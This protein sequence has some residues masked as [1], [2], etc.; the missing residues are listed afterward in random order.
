MSASSIKY[1]LLLLTI[2]A[3]ASHG[4]YSAVLRAASPSPLY[5]SQDCLFNLTVLPASPFIVL[6]S[7]S[8]APDQGGIT[9]TVH[10]AGFPAKLL[11]LRDN[12]AVSFGT[13]AAVL[14]QTPAT[15]GAGGSILF[16]RAP[17]G[18]GLSLISVSYLL[19]GNG[20]HPAT[21]LN[22]SQTFLYMSSTSRVKCESHCSCDL[23]VNTPQN[24]TF[25]VSADGADGAALQEPHSLV[26]GCNVLLDGRPA[27][28]GSDCFVAG[29]RAGPVSCDAAAA[30]VNIKCLTVAVQIMLVPSALQLAV[31]PLIQ[32]FVT[33]KNAAS[34]A[35]RLQVTVPVSFRRS[36]RLL[37]AIFSS[38][39]G[40]VVLTFDQATNAP[41]LNCFALFNVQDRLLGDEPVCQW[42]SPETMTIVL[43]S[44]ATILPGD[45]LM[46]QPDLSDSAS[47][48]VPAENLSVTVSSPLIPLLPSVTVSGPDSVSQCDAAQLSASVSAASGATFTWNCA[49]DPRLDS[50]LRNQTTGPVV[51]ILGAQL[52][53]G[54]S[55]FISVQARS[56]FGTV[57]NLA[58]RTLTRAN[59]AQ[60]LIAIKMQPPPCFRSSTIYFEAAAVATSCT[61]SS[62]NAGSSIT[63]FW[64]LS[65][66][67]TNGTQRPPAVQG[68]GPQ[69]SVPAGVLEAG[70]QFVVT[71]TG[72]QSGLSPAKT[73]QSFSI[74]SQ[75]VVA[76]IAGGGTR[77]LYMRGSS[78][79]DASPSYDPDTCVYAVN[80]AAGVPGCVSPA[81]AGALVFRWTCIVAGVPCSLA[82]NGS[83]ASFSAAAITVLDLTLLSLPSPAPSEVV[84]TVYVSRPG[85]KVGGDAACA[86][87]TV[88]ISQTPTIDVQ[89]VPLYETAE[90][91]AYSAAVPTE[92]KDSA[93]YSWSLIGMTGSAEP[94][95]SMSDESTFLAGYT[96]ASFVL[97]LV[98]ATAAALSA[99]GA[100]YAVSL[101]V[102]AGTGAGK[103][104][105]ALL[106]PQQPSGGKCVCHP[107]AGTPLVT[108]FAVLCAD[109]AA[110]NLPMAYSYAAALQGAINLKPV[111]PLVSWSAP[112]PAPNY[113]IFLLA[114]NYSVAARIFDT[115]GAVAT[116][117]AA[118]PVVVGASGGAGSADVDLHAL[119]ALSDILVGRGSTGTALT[120]FDS[121]AASLNT[122]SPSQQG[123]GGSR[124]LAGSSAAY[125][126][127]VRRMLLQRLSS[128]G[129]ATTM[130][131]P[132]II[133]ATRRAV[134]VPAEV[135][136]P[137]AIAAV[138]QLVVALGAMDLRR[139]RTATTFP[140]A[141][142]LVGSTLAA[143]AP[144]L[145]EEELAVL[146]A[147]AAAALLAAAQLYAAGM[148]A[149]E[150]AK[151]IHAGG[152]LVLEMASYGPAATGLSVA[153]RW[154]PAGAGSASTQR[155]SDQQTV[156][157]SPVAV[158]VLRIDTSVGSPTA[159]RLGVDIAS[160][161]VLAIRV[162]TAATSYAPTVAAAEAG[163]AAESWACPW[164]TGDS[165]SGEELTEI[166]QCTRFEIAMRWT[167]GG[168][169]AEEAQYGCQRWDG[170]TWAAGGC[171]EAMSINGS[172]VNCS[173]SSDGVFTVAALFVPTMADMPAPICG[174]LAPRTAERGAMVACGTLCIFFAA[175]AAGLLLELAALTSRRISLADEE[176][177]RTLGLS[178]QNVGVA[179]DFDKASFSDLFGS[180]SAAAAMILTSASTASLPAPAELSTPTAADQE[181]DCNPTE[182]CLGPMLSPPSP[183]SQGSIAA[184]S[185]ALGLRRRSDSLASASLLHALDTA[186]AGGG[187]VVISAELGY[188]VEQPLRATPA[189]TRQLR[190]RPPRTS[191]GEIPAAFRPPRPGRSDR[192]QDA[193][194]NPGQD[195]DLGAS[196]NVL[197]DAQCRRIVL[198]DIEVI[199]LD[200]IE[201]LI[202]ATRGDSHTLSN[203]GSLENPGIGSHWS[204]CLEWQ[205]Q[206]DSAARPTQPGR[207][208]PPPQFSLQSHSLCFPPPAL[209]GSAAA[210]ALR[211]RD[212]SPRGKADTAAIG[213]RP[214]S[215]TPRR[216]PGP[217][218]NT[219]VNVIEYE[220]EAP[221]RGSDWTIPG[222]QPGSTA[223][224]S[225]IDC[226][227]DGPAWHSLRQRCG[228]N[229][230]KMSR[231]PKDAA[232]SCLADD[233]ALY[234][235]ELYPPVARPTSPCKRRASALWPTAAATEAAGAS[236]ALSSSKC[237]GSERAPGCE[238]GR[239]APGWPSGTPPQG[240]FEFGDG[241]SWQ[242]A[243]TPSTTV[244]WEVWDTVI[245]A[246]DAANTARLRADGPSDQEQASEASIGKVALSAGWG[247]EE[248]A[249]RLV[250]KGQSGSLPISWQC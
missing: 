100:T 147:K 124:R 1:L 214:G 239:E 27:G 172:A 55:Y 129:P 5:T 99:P 146:A 14:L 21:E 141:A 36:P 219:P 131:A 32:G 90:R 22:A 6:I 29:F 37:S 222:K 217:P 188:L 122:A 61:S 203:N 224:P 116:F 134:A 13:S 4:V 153:I 155:R 73:T 161:E 96:G 72:F 58:S 152:N 142:S 52:K 66:V 10:I 163:A 7:P 241:S 230:A 162:V 200:T 46:M 35:V 3:M 138:E 234:D 121:V 126:T 120:L 181:E 50:V 204:S 250:R 47:E 41:L 87:V 57:S 206:P 221:A 245:D 176:A 226:S 228:W 108:A 187:S 43:G 106:V 30:A 110:D 205:P 119:N 11:S 154:L 197:W 194:H 180:R 88:F 133:R 132:A 137:S 128:A 86:I 56:R 170:K 150:A 233:L 199:W 102:T 28:S 17:A 42:S 247:R 39:F 237:C 196:P 130:T 195:P 94:S 82:S 85:T 213:A 235:S 51:T 71:L 189:S 23:A 105:M 115:F 63:F 62:S 109:W 191:L 76:T 18:T 244:L 31:R 139:V 113:E 225:L 75:P 168:S 158:A 157:A 212:E 208:P 218:P 123:R 24:I 118:N 145:T 215:W 151:I 44:G 92:A 186:A 238:A 114:G 91:V 111:D 95:I 148:V 166:A 45:V 64:T 229:P 125:R 164:S 84:M 16:V 9:V 77:A 98:S 79:L 246:L 202:R 2:P 209:R 53:S 216:D 103:A 165:N 143:A 232:A 160:A 26:L 156:A 49:N 240:K 67:A 173:C 227:E 38:S 182:K 167:E 127:A 65:A 169:A 107:T 34:A 101:T 48:L 159:A 15:N 81:A 97:L 112:S 175:V 25:L 178:A 69:L 80:G 220:P 174:L 68:S 184:E 231:L 74:V 198:E 89:I 243:S 171:S 33:L 190:S 83:T 70:L 177:E 210:A 223:G 211:G 104:S 193:M 40:R 59:S 179:N 207:P 149:T 185:R 19:S 54:K 136:S 60:P 201:S 192:D 140:D 8:S 242:P 135:D 248:D 93:T 249:D 20:P 183:R 144:L 78:V 236:P 117:V 12:I